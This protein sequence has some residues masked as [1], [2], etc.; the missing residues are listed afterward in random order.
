MEFINGHSSFCFRKIQDYPWKI[1]AM[2]TAKHIWCEGTRE[3]C[4]K[5]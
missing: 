5:L 3:S 4:I 1:N 2:M